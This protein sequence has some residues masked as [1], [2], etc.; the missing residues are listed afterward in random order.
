MSKTNLDET[1]N[2]TE[3]EKVDKKTN[4]QEET[5]EKTEKEDLTDNKAEEE[6]VCEEENKEETASLADDP[7]KKIADLQAELEEAKKSHLYLQ[8]EFDNY[9]KRTLMEKANLIKMGGESVL[10]NLLPIV[11]DFERALE[12]I[13]KAVDVKA[14]TEGVDLIYNKFM[15]YLKQQGVKP[16]ETKGKEFDTDMFDALTIIPAPTKDLKGKIIDC[17]QT[18]YTLYEKVIRH[19]KVIVGK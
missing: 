10:V 8:A 1:A 12:N 17:V 14:V 15:K 9:R 4:L 13:D 5:A 2:K 7:E 3:E 19:A 11:D 18:G 16:I 6:P